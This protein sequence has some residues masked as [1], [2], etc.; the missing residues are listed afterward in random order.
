MVK[1]L[2]R[3]LRLDL[4]IAVRHVVLNVVA[5]SAVVP[6]PVRQLIY[7]LAGIRA[8]TMNVFS[9]VRITGSDL[10]LG[11]GTFVNH[12]CYLDVAGGRIV[13]GENCHLAPQVMVM[14]ATHDISSG[15]A[16]REPTYATT[17]IGDEV[18][19]GARSTVLPGVTIGEGCVVAAG[20]VVVG[21][22]EPHGVYAGVPAR[23]IKD[24]APTTSR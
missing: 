18:W 10:E 13:I 23:R 21:D 24:L 22:C 12:E 5:G 15:K 16:S 6:R 17:T 3:G 19:L 11:K 2:V 9:G 20:A 14:T 4:S 8:Q 1:A 7:R